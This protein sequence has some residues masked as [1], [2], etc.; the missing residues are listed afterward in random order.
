MTGIEG[1]WSLQFII[2]LIL[3]TLTLFL[4]LAVA[5]FAAKHWNSEFGP[6]WT[7]GALIC[8][9]ILLGVTACV[10]FPWESQ[11]HR[12]EPKVG[13]VFQVDKRLVKQGEGMQEKLVVQF[14]DLPGQWGC[15]DTRCASVRPGD[16]LALRCI[17]RWDYSASEG[18]DCRFV[19][20]ERKA[21]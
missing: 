20:H 2:G 13:K 12:Y 19:A 6:L 7:V 1:T 14:A 10:T 16:M 11:Y 3:V 17:K 15:E 4:L 9:P 18:Y 8:I 5:V 21:A